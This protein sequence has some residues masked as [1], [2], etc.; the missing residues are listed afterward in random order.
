M[1]SIGGSLTKKNPKNHVV[2]IN[3]IVPSTF[4]APN[5]DPSTTGTRLKK[6]PHPMPFKTMKH[7]STAIDDANGHT[8]SMLRPVPGADAADR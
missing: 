2:Q 3:G 8:T 4:V 5:A 6:A 1:E 7:M